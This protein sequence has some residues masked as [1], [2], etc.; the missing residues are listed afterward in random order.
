MGFRPFRRRRRRKEWRRLLN[1][2]RSPRWRQGVR[3][4]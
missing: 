2:N 4:E 3:T 1:T